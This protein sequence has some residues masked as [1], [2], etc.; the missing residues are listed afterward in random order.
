MNRRNTFTN[1]QLLLVF[2]CLSCFCIAPL[3]EVFG[4]QVL[5]AEVV[6]AS[7]AGAIAIAIGRKWSRSLGRIQAHLRSAVDRAVRLEKIAETQRKLDDN[8]DFLRGLAYA[9]GD[10]NMRDGV[11]HFGNLKLGA[12]DTIVDS[13]RSEYGGA[14]TLFTGDIRVSTNIK[15]PDGRSV[16]GTRLESGPAHEAIFVAGASYRGEVVLFDEPY[17]AIYEPIISGSDIL[18][19]GSSR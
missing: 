14:A 7:C 10:P 12:D 6:S 8:L 5:L 13:V 4:V 3:L 11:L 17:V 9:H 2:L 15:G 16:T 1:H 18:G 19:C